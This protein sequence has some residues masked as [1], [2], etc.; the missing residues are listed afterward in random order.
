MLKKKKKKVFKDFSAF[1]T[2][3]KHNKG[4]NFKISNKKI[5][6][7]HENHKRALAPP[8]T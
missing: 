2:V 3:Y 4:N 6:S 7:H 8:S 1:Q 5:K